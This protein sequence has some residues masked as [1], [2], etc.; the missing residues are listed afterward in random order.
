MPKTGQ[1]LI[2]LAKS[3]HKKHRKIFNKLQKLPLADVNELFHTAHEHVF[4]HIYCLSCANCCKT[5]P[6]LLI[7]SDIERIAKHLRI[8]EKQFLDSYTQTDEDGDAIFKNV[9]CVFLNEDNTCQIYEV[10]PKACREYP[11]TNHHNMKQILKLTFR[12]REVCPA[13]YEIV[14]NLED[15]G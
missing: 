13:V 12:N 5:T 3:S 14:E 7:K 15:I 11:H 8:S 10:R 2:S 9:P 1:E 6:A 4:S